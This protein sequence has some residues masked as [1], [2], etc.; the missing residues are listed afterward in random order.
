MVVGGAGEGQISTAV[1]VVVVVVVVAVVVGSA[2]KHSLAI[3]SLKQPDFS[4][5]RALQGGWFGCGGVK[6]YARETL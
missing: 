3:L 6:G 5:R 4:L 1:I 2:T